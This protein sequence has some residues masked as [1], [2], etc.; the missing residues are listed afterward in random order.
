MPSEPPR[1]PSLRTRK[2]AHS[3]P[4]SPRPE[5]LRPP[6]TTHPE[7]PHPEAAVSGSPVPFEPR[8][9]LSPRTW[10]APRLEAPQPPNT[11]PSKYHAPR[12]AGALRAPHLPSPRTRKAPRPE[13]PCPSDPARPEPG[14]PEVLRPPGPSSSSPRPGPHIRGPRH[15]SSERMSLRWPCCAALV[16]CFPDRAVLWVEAGWG[17]GRGWGFGGVFRRVFRELGG[18]VYTFVIRCRKSFAC[19]GGAWQRRGAPLRSCA[20]SGCG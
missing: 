13:A 1:L 10:K 2:P 3:G 12:E 4:E 6:N 17:L 15:S 14:R 20:V 16:P 11:T 18:L 19:R 9:P 7:A 5:A 8:P